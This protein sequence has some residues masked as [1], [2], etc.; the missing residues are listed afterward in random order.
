M[1]SADKKLEAKKPVNRIDLAV[2]QQADTFIEKL[3]SNS[4]ASLL[5]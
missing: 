5:A 3:L 2:I 1:R 4:K